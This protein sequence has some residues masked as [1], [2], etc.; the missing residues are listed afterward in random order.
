M[1]R[2]HDIVAILMADI[3]SPVIVSE[4]DKALADNEDERQELLTL[5]IM[6]VRRHG[7]PRAEASS[8]NHKDFDLSVTDLVQRYRADPHSGYSQL[9]FKTRE[10]YDSQLRRLESDIGGDKIA[11]LTEER[12]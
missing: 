1:K 11:S 7:E 3:A 12:L 2:E 9:R 5:R 10:N 4:I 6:A 8:D